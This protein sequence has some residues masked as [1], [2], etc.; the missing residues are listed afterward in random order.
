M[1][2][3]LERIEWMPSPP[4]APDDGPIDFEH[5]SRMTLG[6]AGLEQEVLAMFVAQSTTLVSTLAAMPVDA[7]ALAH[8]LKGSARAIGAFAVGDAAARLEAAIARGFDTSAALA[9]LGETVAEAR[10]AIEAV[11]RRS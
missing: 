7:S 1:P 9:E 11:L 6:D 10:A 3:H 4:L 2:L 8:T 5:L